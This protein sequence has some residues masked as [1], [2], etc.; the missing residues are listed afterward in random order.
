MRLDIAF[1][2]VNAPKFPVEMD[3][4]MRF[5]VV[6]GGAWLRV[7][8]AKLGR[9]SMVIGFVLNFL[10]FVGDCTSGLDF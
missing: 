10:Y 2:A 3:R 7:M 8:L 6:I 5:S 4:S 9:R 1:M